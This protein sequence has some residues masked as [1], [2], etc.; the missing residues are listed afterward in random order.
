[1][2]AAADANERCAAQ[3]AQRQN[4]KVHDLVDMVLH[5]GGRGCRGGV[6][7]VLHQFVDDGMQISEL[8]L[9]E[10]VLETR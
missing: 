7:G 3:E 2:R 1:M 10:H 9:T 4:N 5:A 6:R 8:P